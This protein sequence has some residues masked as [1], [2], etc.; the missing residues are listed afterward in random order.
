MRMVLRIVPAHVHFKYAGRVVHGATLQTCKRQDGS[1]IDVIACAGFVFGAACRFVAD[2]VGPCA[3]QTRGA[4]GLVCVNHHVVTGGF[5]NG[6]QVMVYHPLA[7]MVLA[8]GQ[9]VAHVAALHGVVSILVHELIGGFHVALVVAD[10][11]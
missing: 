11:R 5:L 4:D 2:E 10:G 6:V 9:Y 8:A 3:A 1:M 7:V